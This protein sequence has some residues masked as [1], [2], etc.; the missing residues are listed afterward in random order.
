MTAIRA[1][2]CNENDN[3]QVPDAGVSADFYM[4]YVEI[5]TI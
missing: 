5:Q 1:F 2:Y 3:I 4:R